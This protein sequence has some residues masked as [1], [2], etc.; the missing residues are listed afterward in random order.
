MPGHAFN[1][2]SCDSLAQ[3]LQDFFSGTCNITTS[4]YRGMAI[5]F[6]TDRGLRQVLAA[7]QLVN[8][9]SHVFVTRNP[10]VTRKVVDL[11]AGANSMNMNELR[12]LRAAAQYVAEC[13]VRGARNVEVVFWK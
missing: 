12:I 2:L 11:F 1:D 3:M 7:M 5:D 10:R 13:Q 8:E 4:S 9:H 6:D